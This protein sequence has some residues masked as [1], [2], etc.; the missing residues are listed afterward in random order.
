MCDCS[1]TKSLRVVLLEYY[2]LRINYIGL[3]KQCLALIK[4]DFYGVES[5]ITS[6]VPMEQEFLNAVQT[7]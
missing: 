6:V 2:E 5:E 7:C 4:L 1:S 3:I